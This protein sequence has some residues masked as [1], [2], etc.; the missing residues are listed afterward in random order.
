MQE[1]PH[2]CLQRSKTKRREKGIEREGE[3]EGKRGEREMGRR[4]RVL[5][6]KPA[7]NLS[8]R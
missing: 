7:V 6:V 4:K 8:S 5:D 3:E 2:L 1:M